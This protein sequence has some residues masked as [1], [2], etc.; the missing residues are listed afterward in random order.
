MSRIA[1]IPAVDGMGG[2]TSFRLRFEAGLRR[3]GVDVT[4]N[5]EEATRSVLVIAGTR[6]LLPLWRARQRGLRVVQRLDGINWVQRRKNTGLRHFLRAEYGNLILS[7]IRSRI[8]THILYQS[9]FSHRWW[10]DWYGRPNIPFSVVHNGVDLNVYRPGGAGE[11]PPGRFRVLI[12]EGNFGGGYDM[13]LENAIQL[14]ETLAE[15]YHLPLELVV[16]GRISEEQKALVQSRPGPAVQWAGTVPRDRIPQLDR[17][18]HLLFSADL[19]PACPNSVVEALACGLPVVGFDT[20]ALNELIVGDSGRLVAYGGDV[21][22]LDRPD[23]AALA[24]AAAEILNDQARFRQA[25]R[26]QAEKALGLDRMMDGYLKI[27]LEA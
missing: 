12:V 21:W 6:N 13:G 17:S 3:R 25:A 9:E 14:T 1:I 15:Q 27:L 22:K 5:P 23:I 19:N 18:A 11:L 26:A 10:D 8:A 24:R 7:F 20:G 4:H 2:M 16:V